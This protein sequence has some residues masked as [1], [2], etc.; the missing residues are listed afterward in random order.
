MGSL[1]S[2]I[3]RNGLINPYTIRAWLRSP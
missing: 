3:K 2:F 1:D